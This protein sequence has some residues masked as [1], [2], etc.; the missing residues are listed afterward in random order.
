M[1]GLRVEIVLV[2]IQTQRLCSELIIDLRLVLHDMMKVHVS[3]LV[4][5]Q[6]DIHDND[7]LTL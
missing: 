1:G 3:V 6:R 7:I 5:L 4:S 2:G